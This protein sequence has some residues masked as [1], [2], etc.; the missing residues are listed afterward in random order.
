MSDP[1]V[2]EPEWDVELD[3]PPFRSRAMRLGNRAGA[4][5]IGVTLYEI[6]PGGA[7]A[8]YHLHHGNE[9]LLIVLAGTPEL[10]TPDGVRE[11]SA[12]ATVAF[13]RGEAGAHRLSNSTA[14][15][16]PA[17]LLIVSTM[18]FPEVA[19]H[20]DTG[21]WLAITGPQSGKTFPAGSDVP[22]MESVV[23][24]MQAAVEPQPGADG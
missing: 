7:I 6:E 11:L 2:H 5:E 12:G 9:E 15:T 13:P 22:F 20:P 18:N 16:Q 4:H 24:A 19:E 3:E 1:N 10:R 14:A 8:P 23:T 21:T 17:R